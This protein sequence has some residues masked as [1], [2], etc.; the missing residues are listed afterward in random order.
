MSSLWNR[1]VQFKKRPGRGATT[2]HSCLAKAL[3]Q[4]AGHPVVGAPCLE[5]SSFVGII[6]CCIDSPP[7][8]SFSAM[9]VHHTFTSTLHSN[10]LKL[11]LRC[12][13]EGCG[14]SWMPLEDLPLHLP[15][16]WSAVGCM[17]LFHI[18]VS[19]CVCVCEQGSSCTRL[20]RPAKR[21][22]LSKIILLIKGQ[23]SGNPIMLTL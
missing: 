6:G 9:L 1:Y 20:A 19:L 14:T 11:G 8:I 3:P 15:N 22:V 21:V 16:S 5:I 7:G 17:A 23:R 13:G 4:M 12:S 18:C 2:A 10:W